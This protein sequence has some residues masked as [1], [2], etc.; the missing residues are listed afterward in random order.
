MRVLRQHLTYA[1]VTA[2]LA[3]FIAL[4]GTSYAALTLPRNSVGDRQIRAGAVR[5]SEVKDRS[6]GVRDLSLAARSSLRGAAGPAGPAGPTGAAA[7]KYFAAVNAAGQATR[8]NATTG[9]RSQGVGSY[10]IG[11]AQPVHERAFRTNPPEPNGGIGRIAATDSGDGRVA[12]T[13]TRADGAPA[14][15]PFHLIVAC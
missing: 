13:T 15:L 3:L 2:T 8:G 6:L 11:F 7:V 9:G 1:N 14:D 10:V 4:G 5:S 12:V